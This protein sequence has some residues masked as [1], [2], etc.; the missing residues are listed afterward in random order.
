MGTVQLIVAL[1]GAVETLT[2]EIQ[3]MVESWRDG[4][5]GLSADQLN[6]LDAAVKGDRK[7]VAEIYAAAGVK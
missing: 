3:A 1:L 5:P 2:P 4:A 7:R 6:A